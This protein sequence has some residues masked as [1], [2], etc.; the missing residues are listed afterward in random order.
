MKIYLTIILV[1]LV[2]EFLIRSWVRHLNLRAMTPDLPSEFEG[3]YNAQEYRQSQQYTRAK[4]K[5]A[6]FSSTV[7]LVVALALIL[8]G[9][10]NLLDTFCR[11]FG[12][13][14][15]PTGLIFFGL[16]FLA[17]DWLSLPF[18]L[19]NTFVIEARFG[20]NKTTIPTFVID[21]LKSYLLSLV[22]GA[23]LLSAILY[24]FQQLGGLA[25]LYAWGLVIILTVL[26]PPI[27]TTLIAPLFNKFTPLEDGAL[28]TSIRDY[29]EQVQFP[30]RDLFVMDGSRRSAHANA[31]FTGFGNQ[32][33]IVLFDTLI[34]KHSVEE[35]VAVIAHEV[36]H[37]KKKHLL[38]GMML[39]IVHS[40]VL[41][42]LLSLFINNRSL[43]DA[44]RM[45][46]ISV[47]A[48]LIFFGLL[49]SPIEFALSIGMHALSRQHEYQADAYAV[50]TLG[51]AETLILALK[52]LSVANL[53]NLTPHPINVFLNYSHPPVLQRITAMRQLITE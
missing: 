33:R 9:G 31:Y 50:Q 40:G 26:A 30:L 48:G 53:G 23:I 24:F 34:E 28:K 44:F 29:T 10:F 14:P 2:G 37:Y 17:N 12:L 21:K 32:K 6:Y 15:V 3:F 36:G 52:N 45:D 27:F 41:F 25:W 16:L 13:L 19:Y 39:S 8:G 18:T 1:A 7:S 11:S 43:F 20:F 4:T 51:I 38:K 22:I 46:Q 35:L 5:L 47:Y 42:Y 49:Y